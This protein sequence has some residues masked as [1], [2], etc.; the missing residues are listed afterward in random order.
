M[1]SL[2]SHDEEADLV[3]EYD[4]QGIAADVALRVYSARLLGKVRQLV[5]HGGGKFLDIVKEA[6]ITRNGHNCLIRFGNLGPKCDRVCGA[7]GAFRR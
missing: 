1:E 6:T 4:K 7:E 3:K 5:L 2:W